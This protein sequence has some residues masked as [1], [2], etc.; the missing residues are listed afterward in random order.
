MSQ[1]NYIEMVTAEF[2]AGQSRTFVVSG[3]YFELID[4]PASVDVFLVDRYGAQRGVMRAAEASFNLKNTE[5]SE[6]QIVSP[7]AQTIRFA[8]GTGEAG[9]RRSAGQVSLAGAVAVSAIAAP[10]QVSGAIDVTAIADPVQ[11]AELAFLR[12]A[13]IRY[14]VGHKYIPGTAG[15]SHRYILSNPVGSGKTLK[16]DS[17]QIGLNAIGSL[18]FRAYICDQPASGPATETPKTYNPGNATA[19]V[20]SLVLVTNKGATVGA[21]LVAGYTVLQELDLFVPANARQVLSVQEVFIPPG[22]SLVF[23]AD[24]VPTT[25]MNC[26]M[27]WV[28]V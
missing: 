21:G 5:F 1:S 28:E 2:E 18:V 26:A 6:I 4:S 10:V 24:A 16:V 27:R 12:E 20:A 19:S 11:V 7:T 9:T 8:Y 25:G 3:Q 17:A 15:Q 14:G 23:D 22:C 13:N